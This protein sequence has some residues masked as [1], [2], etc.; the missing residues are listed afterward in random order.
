MKHILLLFAALS[1]ASCGQSVKTATNQKYDTLY[2]ASY[3]K[4]FHILENKDSIILRV[5]NPWQ[6]A[7]NIT[8]D[9]SFAKQMDRLPKVICMS[10][11]HVAYLNELGLFENI[12]GVS[13]ANFMTNPKIKQQ[14]VPEVGYDN[15]LNYEVIVALKPDFVFVYEVAGGNNATIKKLQQLGINVVYVADYL[16]NSPLGRTEWLV[17]FGALFGK[18]EQAINRME[19]ITTAYNRIKDS[20]A[21]IEERKPKVMLNSPYKDVW[22]LPSDQSYMV[23]LINDAG[24]DYLGKGVDSDASRPVSVE[25][26]YDLLSQADLWLN[27]SMGLNTMAQIREQQHRF[28]KLPV[29]QRGDVYNNDAR[30]TP[31]GGSDF[32]ESGSVNADVILRDLAKVFHPDYF[33]NDEF[34]YY[35]K[36]K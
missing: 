27:P 11:S 9:Y 26:A 22:Y 19:Q 3:A 20:V 15:S 23:Q 35:R 14:N 12:V 5:Y 1:F 4:R 8:Y 31:Q 33:K 34:Y 21:K 2:K 28:A 30:N 25:T 16:E 13:G 18:S 32:W 24:G 36:V 10:S 6:G 29:V 7:E 17:A